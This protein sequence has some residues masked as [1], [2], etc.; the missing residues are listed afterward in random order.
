[1]LMENDGSREQ[2]ALARERLGDECASRQSWHQVNPCSCQDE[3]QLPSG[4]RTRRMLR[5]EDV[6]IYYCYHYHYHYYYSYC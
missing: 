2:L 3:L 5:V 4:H 6:P 1:M